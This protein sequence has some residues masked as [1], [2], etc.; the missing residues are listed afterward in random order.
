MN[1]DFT[2]HKIEFDYDPAGDYLVKASPGNNGLMVSWGTGLLAVDPAAREL[3]CAAFLVAVYE[4]GAGIHTSKSA[5]KFLAQIFVNCQYQ[6]AKA[7]L[8]AVYQAGLVAYLR[9]GAAWTEFETNH[10]QIDQNTFALIPG[11]LPT[12]KETAQ[13]YKGLPVSVLINSSV[14]AAASPE[15]IAACAEI[16]KY[17]RG[18]LVR[19]LNAKK[20]KATAITERSEFKADSPGLLLVVNFAEFNPGNLL[21]RI[22]VGNL[23]KNGGRPYL[24]THYEL[25]TSVDSETP[26]LFGQIYIGDEGDWKHAARK[27]HEKLVAEIQKFLGK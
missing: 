21:A 27:T 22:L 16:E 8:S 6:T 20:V 18:D 1:A 9:G 10:V 7:A 11:N 24:L 13:D 12:A 17:S 14:D 23:A 15:L 19:I 5:F 4:N 2:N 26:P 3:V 25:G